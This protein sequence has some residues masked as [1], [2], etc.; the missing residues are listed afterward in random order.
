[1]KEFYAKSYEGKG[2]ETLKEHS[3]KTA[4]YAYYK[5]IHYGLREDL[6]KIAVIAAIFHDCG[7]TSKA[8]QE[9]LLSNGNVESPGHNAVGA[10]LFSLVVRLENVNDEHIVKDIIE[11]HHTPYT[12]E[13]YFNKLY[14]PEDV[15]TVVDYYK[16]IV[17]EVENKLNLQ[18]GIT[19]VDEY[20]VDNFLYLTIKEDKAFTHSCNTRDVNDK[21]RQMSRFTA[22]FDV[23]RYADIMASQHKEFVPQDIIEYNIVKPEHYE[24]DRYTEQMNYVNDI[25]SSNKN[26]SCV[27]APTGY[28]KTSMG[29]M[30]VLKTGG[31]CYWI[32]PE[33]TLAR[34]AYNNIIEHVKDFGLEN[35]S[36]S[37]LLSGKWEEGTEKENSNIIVTN[38]DNFE[39]NTF[40]NKRKY[41]A[42]QHITRTCI[43]DE[44]HKYITESPLMFSFVTTVKARCLYN[45]VNT[46]L[47]SATPIFHNVYVSEK[48]CNIV[49]VDND[50]FNNIEYHFTFDDSKIF[51]TTDKREK[52]TLIINATI[53]QA[54][55]N[56]KGCDLCFHSYFTEKD[57]KKKTE[58]I[59]KTKGKGSCC[60]ESLSATTI[61]SE[62]TN[63]SYYQL[64]VVNMMLHQ[65]IQ[66]CGRG[67]RFD[68]TLPKNIT[69]AFDVDNMYNVKYVIKN[70][71]LVKKTYTDLKTY[72]EKNGNV[73][74]TKDVN[75]LLD[76]LNRSDEMKRYIYKCM[77]ASSNTFYDIQFTEGNTIYDKETDVKR[78]NTNKLGLRGIP[79]NIFIVCNNDTGEKEVLSVG[80]HMFKKGNDDVSYQKYTPEMI[81]M[82]I[83]YIEDN[84][85]GE[86]YFGKKHNYI[87]K[88]YKKSNDNR[89]IIMYLMSKASD[90]ETPLPVMCGYRYNYDEGLF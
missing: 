20:D 40:K 25:L 74:T 82:A 69:V 77:V 51:E 65:I 66:A 62:G 83:K 26:L 42:I 85:L 61:V 31:Y 89:K 88:S 43:F 21:M 48:D 60:K 63:V 78:N 90:E 41:I 3:I 75:K 32:L 18:L 72:V 56:Y 6:L 64:I 76:E 39:L 59:L 12:I 1:M 45:N 13:E 49:Y 36:V 22:I 16:V 54:Q 8:F 29:L 81:K 9:Y 2:L 11:F 38:I 46:L 27:V 67:N 70:Y 73:L 33:N 35:F 50:N 58:Y 79:D 84:D 44:F 30:Y 47:M 15:L 52:D 68:I 14:K 5:A 34:T 80:S 23:V 4:E 53:K 7:K 24:I 57:K 55:Y 19:F 87:I 17:K 28:G 71:D 10:V 37:L 86:L